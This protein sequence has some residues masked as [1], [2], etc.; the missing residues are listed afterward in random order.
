MEPWE[1]AKR[2]L[3]SLRRH[4]TAARESVNARPADEERT[5]AVSTSPYI[6]GLWEPV[7]TE[8]HAVLGEGTKVEGVVPR[9]I[10]GTFLRIGPN[11]QFSFR[12]KPYHVFDG[13][14]MIHSVTFPGGDGFLCVSFALFQVVPRANLPIC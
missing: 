13:D 6:Q 2:R 12:G 5:E 1:A 7:E 3:R 4:L 14:G 11:P 8:Q 10:C 9:E